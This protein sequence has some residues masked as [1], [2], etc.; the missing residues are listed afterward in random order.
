MREIIKFNGDVAG[1]NNF[2]M[3]NTKES[4]YF[5]NQVSCHTINDVVFFRV[6]N[7]VNTMFVGDQFLCDIYG[8]EIWVVE[9]TAK[10]EYNQIRK[11]WMELKPIV[12]IVSECYK[13][14]P[15]F[16]GYWSIPDQFV[17]KEWI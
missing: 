2:L 5:N 17:I 16:N 12:M 11:N 9:L 13:Y 6:R 14:F 10:K 3:A 8:N 15:T 7:P 4:C 1:L